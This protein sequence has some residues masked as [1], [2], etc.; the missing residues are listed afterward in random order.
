MLEFKMKYEYNPILADK[1]ESLRSKALDMIK[2]NE[3]PAQYLIDWFTRKI[4]AFVNIEKMFYHQNIKGKVNSNFVFNIK[5]YFEKHFA[6]DIEGNQKNSKKSLLPRSQISPMRSTDPTGKSYSPNKIKWARLEINSHKDIKRLELIPNDVNIF[7]DDT[8]HLLKDT[9]KTYISKED[10]DVFRTPSD[11]SVID[12]EN[13][14]T[15]KTINQTPVLYGS[16][17]VGTVNIKKKLPIKIPVPIHVEFMEINLEKGTTKG[18]QK[19]VTPTALHKTSL[20]FF[21]PQQTTLAN[22]NLNRD[23]R[24]TTSYKIRKVPFMR[25]GF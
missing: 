24:N 1:L 4:E 8:R 17:S 9:S 12:A 20:G 22:T 15:K 10:L 5:E 23:P 18:N 13:G 7:S 11:L 16:S 19:I 2:G 25:K 14:A 3:P 6:I 21:S